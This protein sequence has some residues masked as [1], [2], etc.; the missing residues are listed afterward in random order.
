MSKRDIKH[1]TII[2]TLAAIAT[3]LV[4]GYIFYSILEVTAR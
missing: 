3:L 1:L 2:W 4:S